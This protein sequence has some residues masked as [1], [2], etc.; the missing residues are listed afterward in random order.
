[1]R[2]VRAA[3]APAA[4]VCA[5]TPDR[6]IAKHAIQQPEAGQVAYTAGC[7]PCHGPHLTD[8][9]TARPAREA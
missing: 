2:F 7:V 8:R 3:T 6:L 1:V 4:E 5:M 9:P